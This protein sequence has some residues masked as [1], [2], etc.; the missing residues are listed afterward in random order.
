MCPVVLAV[1]HDCVYH[2]LYNLLKVPK[3]SMFFQV[4]THRQRDIRNE[5][6]PPPGLGLNDDEIAVLAIMAS[7]RHAAVQ[8]GGNRITTFHNM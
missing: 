3:R 4:A 1:E 2:G 8:N 7:E 5:S 6:G